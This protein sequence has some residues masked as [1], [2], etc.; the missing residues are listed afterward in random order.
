[1]NGCSLRTEENLS[2]VAENPNPN[3]DRPYFKNINNTFIPTRIQFINDI[4]IYVCI[5]I[6]GCS[7]R[8]EE[9]LLVVAE[10]PEHLLLLETDAPW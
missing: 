6:N 2:V 7:L 3:H 1:M 8:S 4:H 10:I 9:N 5:G